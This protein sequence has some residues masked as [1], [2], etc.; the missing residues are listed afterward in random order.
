MDQWKLLCL[1]YVMNVGPCKNM[2]L[3]PELGICFVPTCSTLVC[4]L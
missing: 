2:L 1:E 3:V 4:F